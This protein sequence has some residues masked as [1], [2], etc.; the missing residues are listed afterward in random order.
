[1]PLGRFG[2]P[3][4]ALSP[5]GKKQWLGSSHF[6][7]KLWHFYSQKAPVSIHRISGVSKKY[8]GLPPISQYSWDLMHHTFFLWA[9]TCSENQDHDVCTSS[10]KYLLMC[11]LSVTNS[12]SD[13]FLSCLTF[14]DHYGA[15]SWMPWT[16]L[17]EKGRFFCCCFFYF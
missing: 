6:H 11:N 3:I 9:A 16:G 10:G 12:C 1:M 15:K 8:G 13:A 2:S 5:T 17:E 4:R 14:W 7:A